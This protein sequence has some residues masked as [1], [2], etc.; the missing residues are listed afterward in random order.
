MTDLRLAVISDVHGNAF[1]LDAVLAEV[2]DAAPDLVVN[3]GDQIE[4]G[5]DPARAAAMQAGL[6]AVEAVVPPEALVRLAALPLDARLADGEVYACHGTPESAWRN[7]LWAYAGDAYRAR[8]PRELRSLV[9]PLGA[10]V[11]LCGHTHR[12][13]VTRAGDVLV[14]NVGSVSL[15]IDGDPRA[16]WA[17]VERRAG[18]WSVDLRAVPYDVEAAI[19]WQRTHA[20]LGEAEAGML[21]HGTFDGRP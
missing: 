2:R 19:G 9:E 16:R 11:V 7:L 13:G 15:Q 14:V 17:L 8:A 5:A 20:P 3:L 21:R 1:A 6:G 4:G 18:R 10:R 12:A